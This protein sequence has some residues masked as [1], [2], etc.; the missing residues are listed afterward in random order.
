MREVKKKNDKKYI[1][2]LIRKNKIALSL[3]NE[4]NKREQRNKKTE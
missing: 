2:L 3:K 1:P 4:Y